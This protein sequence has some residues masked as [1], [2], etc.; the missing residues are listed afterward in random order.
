[1]PHCRETGLKL[2]TTM[3]S[4]LRAT[5]RPKNCPAAPSLARSLCCCVLVV[6]LRVK[7]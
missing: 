7:T 2:P 5:A 6:P 1:M 3:V 4:P